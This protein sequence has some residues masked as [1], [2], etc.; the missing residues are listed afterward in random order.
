[1]Y[2]APGI[3]FRICPFRICQFRINLAMDA[4]WYI[5][6]KHLFLKFNF[7]EVDL[8]SNTPR[9]GFGSTDKQIMENPL[10]K[11]IAGSHYTD[12][13]IQP[14]EF[15]L[16]NDLDFCEGSIIKYVTRWRYKNGIEDLEKARHY[17]EFLINNENK[18]K[19]E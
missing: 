16:A 4:P 7:V 12:R 1:M 6:I 14:I 10:D 15:I 8:L 19:N 18:S 11:Q 17:I 2:H 3:R 5:K 13:K 9:G